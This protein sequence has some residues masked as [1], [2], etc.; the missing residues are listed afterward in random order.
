MKTNKFNGLSRSV[1]FSLAGVALIGLSGCAAITT[2]I[3]HGSLQT[4]TKMSSSIFLPPSASAQPQVIYVQVKNTTDQTITIK[5]Q[6]IGDLQK[7]GYTITDNPD[8]AYKMV[9]VDILQAGKTTMDNINSALNDGYGG[10]IAGAMIGAG[11]TD[12]GWA[13][14]AA[15]GILGGLAGAAADAFVSDVTY[16]VTTDVQVSV[17]LPKGEKASESVQ[18][19]LRQGSSTYV[20]SNYHANTNWQQY[21]TRVISYADKVNLKFSEA[22]P[23]LSANLASEIANIF[24]N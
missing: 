8:R 2:E 16:A 10:A 22:E 19:N 20:S 6:L 24:A 17:R 1:F 7:E 13:G 12:N 9:Q 15:G 11:T 23:T 21:Q 18:S 4:S 14:G 3:Q 5:D